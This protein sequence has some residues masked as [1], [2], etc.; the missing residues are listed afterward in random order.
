VGETVG[1]GLK[2][3]MK[4]DLPGEEAKRESIYICYV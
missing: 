4:R 1:C 2:G 3:L